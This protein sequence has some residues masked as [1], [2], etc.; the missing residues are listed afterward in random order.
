MPSF[1]V[2][3]NVFQMYSPIMVSLEVILHKSNSGMLES[4][5]VSWQTVFDYIFMLLRRMHNFRMILECF[6]ILFWNS[7]FGHLY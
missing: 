7:A 3:K 6:Q 2:L 1:S 4:L 5:S